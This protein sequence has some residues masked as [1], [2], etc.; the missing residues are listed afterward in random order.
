MDDV[1]VEEGGVGVRRDVGVLGGAVATD[2]GGLEDAVVRGL[3]ELAGVVVAGRVDAQGTGVVRDDAL[4]IGQ[5][6]AG[7][8]IAGAVAEADARRGGAV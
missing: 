8:G 1:E 2:T 6:A 7:V 3:Q 5:Q 4:T